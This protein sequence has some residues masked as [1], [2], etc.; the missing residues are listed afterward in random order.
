MELII[1]ISGGHKMAN[2]KSAKTFYYRE[3]DSNTGKSKWIK[4][5]GITGNNY[6][7]YLDLDKWDKY[8]PRYSLPNQIVYKTSM[9]I[10]RKEFVNDLSGDVLRIMRR[11]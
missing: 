8:T 2:K 5:N 11:K 10:K 9:E 1:L 3:T 7:I 4:V 6:L